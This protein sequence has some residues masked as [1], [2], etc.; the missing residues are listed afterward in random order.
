MQ[1]ITPMRVSGYR[2]RGDSVAKYIQEMLHTVLFLK[3]F[4]L[5]K[6]IEKS[7]L[8]KHV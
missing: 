5:N 3:T 6:K 2:E 4:E 1:N 8:K 7:Y